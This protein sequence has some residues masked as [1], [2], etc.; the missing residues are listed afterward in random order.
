MQR[1]LTEK[2]NQ[3]IGTAWDAIGRLS[4]QIL[5]DEY[6]KLSAMR[7]HGTTDGKPY[8]EPEPPIPDGYRRATGGDVAKRPDCKYW[9]QS[10][11]DWV[12]AICMAYDAGTVF[13]VPVEPP[14]L[15]GHRKAIAGDEG[16]TDCKIWYS[17]GWHDRDILQVGKAFD[18]TA[19]YIVPVDKT[20]TDEDAKNR[21]VVMVRDTPSEPWQRRRLM[22][23]LSKASYP[24]VVP[25][26]S[27]ASTQIFRYCRLPYPNETP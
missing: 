15:G 1:K 5:K 4:C 8:V 13:I 21:P 12:P 6:D 11:K 27:D 3:L 2:E 16:R 26:L 17:Q 20:P 19:K 7:H 24:F 25:S 10:Q 22:G 23:V 18:S 9:S 14:I